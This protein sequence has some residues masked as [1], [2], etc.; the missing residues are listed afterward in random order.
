M[1]QILIVGMNPHTIDFSKPGFLPGLTAE[2]VEAGLKAERENLKTIGFESDMY[3]IDDGVLE[4]SALEDQL[5]A[6]P[7][8]GIMLGAGVRIPPVN[9]ILFEKL[10]N[11]VHDNAPNAKIIFNTNPRDTAESVRRW[12]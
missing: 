1:K 5:K 11:A 6:K 10:V 3:L 2:K 4:L 12:L 8:D 9:F 7:F